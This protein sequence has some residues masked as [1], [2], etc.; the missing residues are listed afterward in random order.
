MTLER[1]DD[2]GGRTAAV[3]VVGADEEALGEEVDQHRIHH[4]DQ[5]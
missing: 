5:G 3:V 4:Q 2:T 1:R